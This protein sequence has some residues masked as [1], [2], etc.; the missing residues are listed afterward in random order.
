MR[1][2]FVFLKYYDMFQPDRLPNIVRTKKKHNNEM[3]EAW[4]KET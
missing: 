4:K 2:N 1:H 3:V